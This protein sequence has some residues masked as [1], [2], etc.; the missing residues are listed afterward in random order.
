VLCV[1]ACV[2]DRLL[3]GEVGH[4][5]GQGNGGRDQVRYIANDILHTGVEQHPR[6]GV[7]D[8]R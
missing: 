1:D 3:T 7:Y 6:T 8:S 4:H 2:G 5:I